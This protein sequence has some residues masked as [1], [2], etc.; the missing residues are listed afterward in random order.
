[1]LRGGETCSASNFRPDDDPESSEDTV[2]KCT[3]ISGLGTFIFKS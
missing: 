3:E 2:G 1:M